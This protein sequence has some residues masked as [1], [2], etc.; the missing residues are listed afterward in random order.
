MI[1]RHVLLPAAAFAL[2]AGCANAQVPRGTDDGATVLLAGSV[3]AP[4]SYAH[5]MGRLYADHVFPHIL[6]AMRRPAA[7]QAALDALVA[8][9]QDRASPRYHHWLRAADLRRF[10]PAQSDIDQVV[11]WLRAHGFAVAEVSS[12]GMTIDFAASVSALSAAFHTSMHAYALKVQCT[13]PTRRRLP[14]PPHSRR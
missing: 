11:A 4:V 9:Q 2:W 14:C 13:W 3:A 1:V 7:S 12:S 6:L 8:S 10:G 5:D